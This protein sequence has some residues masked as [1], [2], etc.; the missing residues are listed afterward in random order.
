MEGEAESCQGVKSIAAVRELNGGSSAGN[1][2][3]KLGSGHYRDFSGKRSPQ[4]DAGAVT[5]WPPRMA[6]SGLNAASLA[7]SQL[8]IFYGGSVCVF[9]GIPME[10]VHEILL[11][12]STAAAAT[13]AAAAAAN[14]SGDEKNTASATDC[15]ASSPVLTRSPSLQSTSTA[16]ASL[17]A[18][19]CPLQSAS[20]C[21]LQAELPITRRHSLQRFFE[22]RRDRLVN[23]NPYPVKHAVEDEK[24]DPGAA[25]SPNADCFEKSHMP[26]ELYPEAVA[27]LA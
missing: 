2:V 3:G 15:P 27:R 8:T 19:G 24:A 1:D 16:V 21:K 10:K 20:L 5:V 23:K 22:K 25:T 9:D 26:Q 14:N 4:K 6:A 12:A 18:Q 7:P 11:V 13:A 17:V